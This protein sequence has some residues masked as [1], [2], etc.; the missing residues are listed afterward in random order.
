MSKP[1][2]ENAD[3]KTLLAAFK[4]R[5]GMIGRL[6]S[7]MCAY[8]IVKEQTTSGHH[9][10]CP[11]HRMF[12][13]HRCVTLR[14]MLGDELPDTVRARVEMELERIEAKETAHA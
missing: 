10:T 12:L 2:W 11:T 6:Q 3:R 5:A 14:A 1:P 9:A 8:P 4:Q 7:C 13:S